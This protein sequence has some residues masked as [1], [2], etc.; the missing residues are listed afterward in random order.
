MQLRRTGVPTLSPSRVRVRSTI[1]AAVAQPEELRQ[2]RAFHKAL[3]DVNRLRIVR[4]LAGGDATVTELTDHVGLSQPLVSWHLGRL[5]A[6][7]VVETR[8]QGRETVCR[9]RGEAF[10]E[11]AARER[12]VLGFVG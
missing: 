1:A 9:L 3:A 8:R 10:A 5:R 2:L 6:A 12:A 11:F 7:G 4:R